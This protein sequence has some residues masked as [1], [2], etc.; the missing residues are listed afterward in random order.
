ME[1]LWKSSSG[2]KFGRLEDELLRKLNGAVFITL[3]TQVQNECM[4]LKFFS[5]TFVKIAQN[6][7]FVLVRL[8][9]ADLRG[10]SYR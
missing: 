5:F 3:G 7:I 10:N 2:C 9:S 6:C 4:F 8:N 1:K